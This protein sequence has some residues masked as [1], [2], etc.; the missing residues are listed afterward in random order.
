MCESERTEKKFERNG[1]KS[2][3]LKIN[4]LMLFLAF[5]SFLSKL[6]SNEQ[7][8]IIQF[9]GTSKLYWMGFIFINFSYLFLFQLNFYLS[10]YF[11]GKC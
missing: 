7:R 1:L 11:K 9:V 8:D 4:S 10:N 5:E 6:V 3:L 2:Q